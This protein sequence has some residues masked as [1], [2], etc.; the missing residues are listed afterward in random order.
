[1]RVFRVLGAASPKVIHLVAPS[2]TEKQTEERKRLAPRPSGHLP[3]PEEHLLVFKGKRDGQ[4][5]QDFL[6]AHQIEEAPGGAL[7][8]AKR[9]HE[10]VGIQNG[11]CAGDGVGGRV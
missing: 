6:S 2:L 8:A 1:V 3:V 9:G 4:M 5:H 11:L 10:D 7:L